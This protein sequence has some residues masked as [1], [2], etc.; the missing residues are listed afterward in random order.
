MNGSFD[1]LLARPFCLCNYIRFVLT[2]SLSVGFD[3]DSV[4]SV[5][6]V[7]VMPAFVSIN[8]LPF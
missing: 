8:L 6:T 2:A 5:S 4:R 3:N 7:N 1:G